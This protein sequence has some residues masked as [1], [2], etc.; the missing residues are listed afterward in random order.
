[1]SAL[2]N[3]GT[4]AGAGGAIDMSQFFQVFFDEAAE[5]LAAMESLLLRLDTGAPDAEELNAI[6]R[7]AHSI[8]GGAGTFGFTDL[9]ELTH[10]AETLLDRLRKNELAASTGMVDVLLAA[11]DALK[12]M[13]ARHRGESGAE[14]PDCVPLVQRIRAFLPGAHADAPRAAAPAA[15]APAAAPAATKKQRVI[16]IG[17]ARPADD[18]GRAALEN[19]AADLAMLGALERKSAAPRAKRLQWRLTTAASFK[20]IRDLFAFVADPAKIELREEGKA[21]AAGP[22]A[23]LATAATDGEPGYGFFDA[24]APAP[25]EDAGYGFFDALPQPVTAAAEP[26]AEPNP[27]RRASDRAAEA[28]TPTGRRA[29]DKIAVNPQGDQASIRVGVDKVDSLINQVGELVITQ[30]MLAQQVSRLDPMEHHALHNALRDLERNTRDLQ[31]SAMAIRMLPMSFVFN[32]FPRMVRDLAAKLGKDIELTTL[33][34]GTELDKG[35]IERITDP[36]N[37]LMRNSVDHGIEAPEERIA[38]GKPAKGTVRLSAGH[39][40]GH[41]VIEIADDGKGLDRAR[42]LAKA[43]ERGLP[44]QDSMGDA[45]VWQ[46][47]F[48]PG[49]STAA[50]V[51]DVSGRG[52][53]MD[54]VKRNI[55]ALGGIVELDSSLGHG[56]R[57]TVKLPLTLAIM[58]GMSVSVGEEIYI[59]PLASVVETLQA[60]DGQ[61]KSV[62][63]SGRVIQVRAEY[64]PVSDLREAFGV[65]GAA[66]GAGSGV[67]VIVEADGAKTALAVDELVGQ[68]QVVVKNLESNYRKVPGVSGATILG[69]GR[70]A[71]ILDVAAL[72][73]LARH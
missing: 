14:A 36:L 32:R 55:L 52:V 5:H 39:R 50:A 19:L 68:Q 9:A 49:F 43:R 33:G 51:T 16:G 2:H 34:E 58:E 47:I 63:G 17:F 18:A 31:E 54:V 11:G 72:V 30:A 4:A 38:A 61:V 23:H 21:A 42:I 40:G 62:S 69:D 1:M 65:D 24:P 46:L 56:M 6:F 15:P 26:A 25:A 59:L 20:E 60:A 64:L 57:V 3:G 37:H 13:L 29:N 66:R 45:E 44:V 41:I 71:L 27:G 8:K 7:A 67:M 22:Y 28:E 73:K 53:G 70:V 12:A 48:E 10:E 35:L